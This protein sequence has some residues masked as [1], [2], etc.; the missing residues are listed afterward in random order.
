MPDWGQLGYGP[1]M[2]RV[3]LMTLLLLAPLAAQLVTTDAG[4]IS[5][6]L[7]TVKERLEWWSREHADELRAITRLSWAPERR[8]Q[9]DLAVPLVA[10]TVAVPSTGGEL[11][12]RQEGLGD[13]TFGAKWALV[14]A[15]DVMRSDR[16]SVLAEVSLPTGDDNAFVDGVDLGPRAAL[17]LGTF[18]GSLGLGYT[19]VRDRHRAAV[20]L[21][22]SAFASDDGFAPGEELALDVA[23]WVRLSPREFLP[24][25]T[26][27]EWRGVLEVLSRWQTDDTVRAIDQQNG[28][29]ELSFVFGLQA[30]LNLAT[31]CEVGV[32][33]PLDITTGSPFGE[34]DFGLLFSFR[35]SF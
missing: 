6:E 30:N 25:H 12:G 18:G 23:W 28:G 26:G 19:L 15:D 17:G 5:P 8:L 16:L 27:L 34:P 29:R 4:V 9:L 7:P 31:S 22:G 10:R 2:L 21:R 32:V 11:R 35:V 13:L 1:V 33:V 14:R 24:E 20:A 3:P